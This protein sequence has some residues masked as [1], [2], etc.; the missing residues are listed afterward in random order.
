MRELIAEIVHEQW[1]SWMKY[2]LSR[3]VENGGA[4]TCVLITDARRWMRQANTPYEDLSEAE[5][6]SDREWAD[7]Y[8][9]VLNANDVGRLTEL[10]GRSFPYEDDMV[11]YQAGLFLTNEGFTV[12]VFTA[13]CDEIPFAEYRASTAKAAIEVALGVSNA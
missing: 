10:E 3:A 8:L 9:A 6:E 7:K 2:Q 12:L 13:D 5:K 4:R 11:C 1:A